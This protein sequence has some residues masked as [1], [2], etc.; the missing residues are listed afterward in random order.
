M[1]DT[2]TVERKT[3]ANRGDLPK[4]VYPVRCRVRSSTNIS[5]LLES[6]PS[7]ARPSASPEGE[8]HAPCSDGCSLHLCLKQREKRYVELQRNRRYEHQT[9]ENSGR[10]FVHV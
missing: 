5:S 8:V 4:T 6:P 7:P 3:D 1:E 9:T 10:L 2:Q